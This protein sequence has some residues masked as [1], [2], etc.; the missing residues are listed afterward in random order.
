MDFIWINR[1][2]R[3]FEWF[4]SLLTKLEMDQAEETQ[5][6]RHG[7]GPA[8]MGVR[9]GAQAQGLCE[10]AFYQK[11]GEERVPLISSLNVTFCETKTKGG[12]RHS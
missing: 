11:Y 8:G 10:E 12:K 2:Q 3:A 1:H 4:V 5:E 9:Q 6:G 7:P